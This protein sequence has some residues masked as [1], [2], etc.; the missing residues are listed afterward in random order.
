MRTITMKTLNLISA[1]LLLVSSQLA[2][3]ENWTGHA[4]LLLGEKQLDK[5]DWQPHETQGSVGLLIDLR[6]QS[7]PVALAVDVFGSGHEERV[8]GRKQESYSA[9]LHLGARYY[10]PVS[11]RFTPYVGAGP[12]LI[13]VGQKLAQGER[14]EDGGHGWWT[15]VGMRYQMTEHLDVGADLRCS[16][17]NVTLDGDELQ[18]GGRNLAMGVGYHW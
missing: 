14:E 6:P 5:Q 18:A 16:R 8:D 13:S 17:A 12:A 4:G 9:E 11:S 7:S 3:A 15:G 2:M 1:S 10:L